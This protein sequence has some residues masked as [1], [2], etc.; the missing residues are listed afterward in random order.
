MKSAQDIDNFLF[1]NGVTI[2]DYFLRVT[3]ISE[4]LCF[5]NRE[6]REFYLPISDDELAEAAIQRLKD[7]GVR[8]VTVG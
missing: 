5:T 6:G 8:I 3:P 2:L 1:G 4:S 7:L